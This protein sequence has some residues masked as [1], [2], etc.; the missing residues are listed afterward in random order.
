MIEVDRWKSMW[1]TLG[2]IRLDVGDVKTT[3]VR[4]SREGSRGDKKG[5]VDRLEFGFG[6]E[7][8]PNNLAYPQHVIHE[9]LGEW[10]IFATE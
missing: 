10:C 1:S 2:D 5:R 8:Y 6:C 3:V 4:A 9:G 7:D